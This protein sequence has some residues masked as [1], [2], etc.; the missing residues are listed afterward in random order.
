MNDSQK[1]QNKYQ[2][3]SMRNSVQFCKNNNMLLWKLVE[4]ERTL[5]LERND[6]RNRQSVLFPHAISITRKK[7]TGKNIVAYLL[8]NLHCDLHRVPEKSLDIFHYK[9][10]PKLKQDIN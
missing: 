3:I 2:N 8:L 7:K 1:S 6:R 9:F 4:I 5:I 10:F